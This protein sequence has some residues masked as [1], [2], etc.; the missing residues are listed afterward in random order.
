MVARWFFLAHP[1]WHEL[2]R[3]VLYIA[4]CY[5]VTH[6]ESPS[7]TLHC[8][9]CTI[10]STKFTSSRIQIQGRECVVSDYIVRKIIDIS[11]LPH[12][13]PQ[14]AK[15]MFII[16]NHKSFWPHCRSQETM[17]QIR[18]AAEMSMSPNKSRMRETWVCDFWVMPK[19]QYYCELSDG[20]DTQN[21]NGIIIFCCMLKQWLELVKIENHGI[22]TPNVWAME[23]FLV[24]LLSQRRSRD[25]IV[26]GG[27][28]I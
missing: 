23:R 7:F 25:S 3:Y 15:I 26:Y 20:V 10:C 6:F 12:S 21:V 27:S 14:Y 1:I 28:Y 22:R 19:L 16:S 18:H 8:R 11:L 9:Y 17:I 13:I 4:G 24:I 5:C 2:L